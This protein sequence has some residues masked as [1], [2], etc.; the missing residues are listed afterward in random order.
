MFIEQPKGFA[1]SCHPHHVFRLKKAILY[2]LKQAPQVWHD[3]L[4]TYL[5]DHGFQRGQPIEHHWS[6]TLPLNIFDRL[7]ITNTWSSYLCWILAVWN[8]VDN[9]KS[10]RSL[11]V[12]ERLIFLSMDQLATMSNFESTRIESTIASK[13]EELKYLI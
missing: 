12:T 6:S 1:D 3:R 2:G 13:S 5:L 8:H 4:T 7:S 9:G 11:R 10:A